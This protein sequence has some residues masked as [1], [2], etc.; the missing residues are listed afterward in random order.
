MPKS[1]LSQ[2]FNA[3]NVLH[4]ANGSELFPT[5]VVHMA[6]IYIHIPFCKSRCIYCGFFSTTSLGERTRYVERLLNELSERRDFLSGEPIDTIYFGGGTPS[7]LPVADVERIL[8]HI[9]YIYNVRANAEVTLEGN[10]DDL[11]P[12]FMRCLRQMGINRLSM[13]VQ[14]FDDDRLRFLRRRHTASQALRAVADAQ[15]A[16]FDNISIDLMF[17]FPG[18]TLD[19]WKS[20]VHTALSLGVQHL[21]AYSLMYEE[22]TPLTQMLERGQFQEIDDELSRQMYEH[23]HDAAVDAGFQHYEISNF[24]LPGHVSR[25]N[26]GYWHG[27][28][29]LGV[30]AGAHSY[31]GHNRYYHTDSLSEYLNDASLVKEELT[32][33][34]RYD[35]FVFTGLR[36]DDG[37]RTDEL[38]RRFGEARLQY[39]LKNARP[40]LA[41][42][43]LVLQGDSLRLSRKGLFVSNDVMSDLMWIE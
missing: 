29:Y 33:D 31:D 1:L 16:G 34:E 43:L 19:E 20:D 42:G 36:T 32:D 4:I 7:Q 10:P 25:H 35:E 27:V 38:A 3:K 23:L 22:G 21:S 18:Q 41:E 9:Y 30:G 13:G 40:H 39:C 6:G 2:C 17:G 37:I 12:D 11:T 28:P 26:S 15:D 8:A 14:S 24:A 5:F